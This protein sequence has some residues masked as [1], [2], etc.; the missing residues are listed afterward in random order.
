MCAD[1]ACQNPPSNGCCEG[2]YV[3]TAVS[4]TS[5]FAG[6]QQG[7]QWV[8]CVTRIRETVQLSQLDQKQSQMEPVLRSPCLALL[9]L[10]VLASQSGKVMVYNI[11]LQKQRHRNLAPSRGGSIRFYRAASTDTAR[12]YTLF[13]PGKPLNQRR[14]CTRTFWPEIRARNIC[15]MQLKVG[16]VKTQVKMFMME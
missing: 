2:S 11:W 3:Q 4:I 13:R 16:M 6:D 10:S 5:P 9:T 15:G 8:A 12:R 7:L 14:L 1:D